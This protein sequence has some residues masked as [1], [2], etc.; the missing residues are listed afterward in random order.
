MLQQAHIIDAVRLPRARVKENQSAY[1]QLRPVQMLEPLFQALEQRN[2]LNSEWVED[3]L[4]GCNTQIDGQGADI[5]KVSALY[6]GWADSVSGATVNRFCCSGLDAINMA[7]SKII[8]GMESVV[9]AGGVEQLSQ[10]PMFS[11]RGDWF[12]NKKVMFKTRFMHMGVSADLIANMHGFS[13]GQLDELAL[14]SHQK[15]STAQSSGYFDKGLVTVHGEDSQV[16]LALDDNIRPSLD[17]A[18][19]SGLPASFSEAAKY[20]PPAI[21]SKLPDYQPLHS[22]GSSPSLVDGAS[23]VLLASAEACKHYGLT[24]RARVSHF[25]NASDDPV[26]MLTGHI[27]STEKLLKAT[28]LTVSDIDLWEVNESFAASVLNYQ[29]H[30]SVENDKLNV[31]GSAIAMGHPLGATGGNLLG[32]ALD[33]LERRDLKRAIISIPGGAGVGVTTLIER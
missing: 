6:A 4:L 12:S 20:L 9:V 3:V 23:L 32:M 2:S 19:L 8:G 28:G 29:R 1:S 13:R 33:E 17:F 31:N 25:S 7:A 14:C 27:K 30:F 10:V 11:D 18:K 22:A 16:L 5:A 15:A 24:S 21:T 26:V